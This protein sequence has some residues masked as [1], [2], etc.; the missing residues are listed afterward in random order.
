MKKQ[1]NVNFAKMSKDQLIELTST[2]KETVAT[3]FVPAKEFTVVDLW[4]IQRSSNTR[5]LSRHLA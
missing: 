5:I 4:N 2:V 3:H 1:T